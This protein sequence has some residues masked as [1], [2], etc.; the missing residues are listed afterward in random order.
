MVVFSACSEAE[1]QAAYAAMLAAKRQAK[2]DLQKAN[3]GYLGEWNEQG[4]AVRCTALLSSQTRCL[5][6]GKATIKAV[7]SGC[8]PRT[9]VPTSA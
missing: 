7:H 8:V 6:L 4:L 9:G 2:L 3:K 1:D 5:L